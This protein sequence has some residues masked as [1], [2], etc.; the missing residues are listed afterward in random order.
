MQPWWHFRSDNLLTAHF[1]PL[2][3]LK[4]DKKTECHSNGPGVGPKSRKVSITSV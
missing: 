3:A 2:L 4:T 1:S